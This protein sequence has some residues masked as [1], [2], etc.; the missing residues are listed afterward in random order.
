MN[1]F[2]ILDI[3]MFLYLFFKYFIKSKFTK[4]EFKVLFSLII[5]FSVGLALTIYP[6]STSEFPIKSF[7]LYRYYYQM[8]DL[9][10]ATF[11]SAISFIF[12]KMWFGFRI[13]EYIVALI[14]KYNNVIF[15]ITIPLTIGIYAYIF[16]H[17][18]KTENSLTKRQI[19]ISIIY[20]FSIVNPI[21]LFSGIRN[22][23]AV[24]IFSLGFYQVK[25]KNKKYGYIFYFLS[26][27]IHPM[28]IILMVLDILMP[29]LRKIKY[30]YVF[31]LLAFFVFPLITY[32][33]NML[34]SIIYIPSIFIEKANS[35]VDE[36]NYY[37]KKIL[38]FEVIQIV[39]MLIYLHKINKDGKLDK[40]STYFYYLCFLD[41][42]FIT[43]S[44]FFIRI[45]F[46][47]AYFMPYIF[48]EK[49]KVQS[50]SKYDKNIETILFIASSIILVHYSLYMYTTLTNGGN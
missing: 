26:I 36:E 4:T 10:N 24:A 47:F 14:S 40:I 23:L 6:K 2:L 16:Y 25:I 35:Y 41:L 28:T 11:Q 20:F 7:D 37:N 38:I 42:G 31:L 34:D 50:D 1:L 22:A 19:I 46:L 21:H 15:I 39:I 33:M 9:R 44:T 18:Y 30:S 45:R 27:T 13:I 43:Y 8:D 5:F 32:F 49:N 48:S 3:V 29:I 12:E 17:I